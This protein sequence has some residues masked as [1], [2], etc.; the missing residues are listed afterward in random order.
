MSTKPEILSCKELTKTRLFRVE[1]LQLK[2]SNGVERTYERLGRFGD[3]HRAVMVV[4]LLDEHR[5]LMIREYA[6]GTEDYQLTLPKGLVEP[7]ETLVEGANRELKEEAGYG[8]K[9]WEVLTRFTLSPNYMCNSIEVV[10]AKNLYEEK[11]E[12]DEPEPLGLEI[13]SFDQLLELSERADFSEARALAAL[14]LAR[15]K[16]QSGTLFQKTASSPS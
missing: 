3:G 9:D 8:A 11:L 4:P 7:G 5:V 10:V 1:E 13:V 6:A 16:L 2:F 15:E 14:F 12:G